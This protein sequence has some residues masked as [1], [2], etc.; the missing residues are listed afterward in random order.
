MQG[1]T[2]LFIIYLDY[3]LQTSID[4]IKENGF[5]LKNARSRQYPA[6]T[7]ADYAND[8]AL[9]AKTSA[10]S[11]SLLYNWEQAAGDIGLHMNANKT[12]FEF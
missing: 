10:Q 1:D 5:M 2:Y 7:D 11:K 8:P 4:L 6:E 3:I 9:L 12:K